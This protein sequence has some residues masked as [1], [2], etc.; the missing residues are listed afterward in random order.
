MGNRDA[1]P[2]LLF[3]FDLETTG[4]APR[5]DSILEVAIVVTDKGLNELGS[6]HSL[7]APVTERLYSQ[8]AYEAHKK[9]GLLDEIAKMPIH[10]NCSHVSKEILLFMNDVK[11][12]A[13][14]VWPNFRDLSFP[15]HPSG[16]SVH[17]DVKHM[18]VT[19]PGPFSQF[20]HR[21]GDVS[22]LKLFY[23]SFTGHDP[24]GKEDE[25]HRAVPDVRYSIGI[26]QWFK[27][28]FRGD[29][30]DEGPEDSLEAALASLP[31]ARL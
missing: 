11:G 7:V 28:R 15:F 31:P 21:H 20:H 19:M 27:E 24:W 2:R 18:E 13:A 16:S 4:L 6:Y 12:Y 10:V 9:S 17:F 8:F 30:L 29:V 3:W 26:A 25:V 23:R 22:A 14:T 5:Y 1:E